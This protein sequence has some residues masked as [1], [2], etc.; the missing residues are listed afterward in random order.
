MLIGICPMKADTKFLET[1]LYIGIP[2]ERVFNPWEF[3]LRC[4]VSRRISKFSGLKTLLIGTGLFQN[5]IMS[6]HR[7]I[8]FILFLKHLKFKLSLFKNLQLF[9]T[10]NP[11]ASKVQDAN[12]YSQV[13]RSNGHSARSTSQKVFIE[14]AGTQITVLSLNSNAFEWVDVLMRFSVS[15]E[16]RRVMSGLKISSMDTRIK[17]MPPNSEGVHFRFWSFL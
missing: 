2:M 10:F 14:R 16:V 13:C 7:T 1:N 17:S 5:F 15:T 9:T 12:L 6:F 4:S 11:V 3:W 8:V